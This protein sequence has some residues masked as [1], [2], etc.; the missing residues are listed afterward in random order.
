ML[1]LQC[2]ENPKKKS[3]RKQQCNKKWKE[4]ISAG[5]SAPRTMSKS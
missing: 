3:E 1:Y 2:L 4:R 5:G